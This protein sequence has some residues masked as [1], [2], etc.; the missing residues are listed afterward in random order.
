MD[1]KSVI[2]GFQFHLGLLSLG[3][4]F[5]MARRALI[6]V[7]LL[8][9]VVAA[10]L[11]FAAG[12]SSRDD[13][14]PLVFWGSPALSDEVYTLIHQFELRNPQYKVVMG[15]AVAPNITGD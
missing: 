1:C 14:I 6:A 8:T 7:V 11:L 15:T 12:H 5:C 4:P 3:I 10:A 9:V 2:R 13:R